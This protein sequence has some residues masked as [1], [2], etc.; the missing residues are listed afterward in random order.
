MNR[1]IRRKASGLGKE[2]S[3][4]GKGNR[5]REN[6]SNFSA[7][8]GQSAPFRASDLHILLTAADEKI[9][10]SM[11]HVNNKPQHIVFCLHSRHLLSKPREFPVESAKS[12]AG[13]GFAR[14]SRARFMRQRMIAGRFQPCIPA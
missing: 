5:G 7:L 9:P 8:G 10:L 14:P 2:S 6:Y 12:L 4:A 3:T 13:C 1:P 11:G